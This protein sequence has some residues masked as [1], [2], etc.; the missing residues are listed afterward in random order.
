MKYT[1]TR[2]HYG[3]RQYHA[4]DEREI[5]NKNDANKLI[6]AGLIEELDSKPTKKAAPKTRNK[7]EPDPDNKAD[8]P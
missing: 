6:K 2:Q 4:G 1:V 8:Q 7:A 5:G 3:D